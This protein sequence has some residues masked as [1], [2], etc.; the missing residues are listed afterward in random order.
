MV[1]GVSLE[2]TEWKM[3]AGYAEKFGLEQVQPFQAPMVKKA[4]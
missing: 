3:L 4:F 1:D 2:D